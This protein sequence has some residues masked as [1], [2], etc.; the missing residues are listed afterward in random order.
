MTSAAF[1]V[2][3]A[4]SLRFELPLP[5]EGETIIPPPSLQQLGDAIRLDPR[6]RGQAH[7]DS[8]AAQLEAAGYNVSA[9]AEPVADFT[10]AETDQERF[11]RLQRQARTMLGRDHEHLVEK[12]TLGQISLLVQ[13][14]YLTAQ[15]KDPSNFLTMQAFL[16]ARQEAAGQEAGALAED[17]DA[18]VVELAAAL[19]ISPAE[20]AKM[21]LADALSVR[22]RMAENDDAAAKFTAAL[23]GVKL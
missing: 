13:G 3:R 11:I 17:I 8:I 18:L 23:A 5:H 19:K 22:A 14:L 20:A 2:P 4:L 21:P 7:L 16:A 6:K 10:P 1:T 12:L 9:P 15:G